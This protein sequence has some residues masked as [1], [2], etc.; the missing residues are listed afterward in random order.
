M[1][2]AGP[3]KPTVEAESRWNMPALESGS[4]LACR[5]IAWIHTYS[6]EGGCNIS[7][8]S[9]MLLSRPLPENPTVHEGQRSRSAHA[10]VALS[11]PRAPAATLGARSDMVDMLELGRESGRF[12]RVLHSTEVIVHGIV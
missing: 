7:W 11:R 10:L 3:R 4:V 6:T 8:R 2:T 5:P 1:L 9:P 12:Q